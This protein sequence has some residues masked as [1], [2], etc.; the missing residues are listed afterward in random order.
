[1]KS[2]Q[3]TLVAK[4][5]S[6][7]VYLKT[8]TNTHTLNNINT[9]LKSCS[10][11]FSWVLI[12]W[13]YKWL[14]DVLAAYELL[15]IVIT[16]DSYK[17][18]NNIMRWLKKDH[19]TDGTWNKERLICFSRFLR[20]LSVKQKFISDWITAVLICLAITQLHYKIMEYKYLD[21]RAYL[22]FRYNLSNSL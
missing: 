11:T 20:I 4:K 17:F 10:Y 9:L 12:I 3:R 5:Y 18:H 19:F 16:L 7:I 21:C 8:Y 6:L 2:I 1:M 15:G 14:Y 13:K 22:Y